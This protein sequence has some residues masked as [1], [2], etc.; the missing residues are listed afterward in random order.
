MCFYN[1]IGPQRSGLMFKSRPLLDIAINGYSVY[2]SVPSCAKHGDLQ[3][4]TDVENVTGS[5]GKAYT[6]PARNSESC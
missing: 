4:T 6:I 3:N 5:N 2:G 1:P